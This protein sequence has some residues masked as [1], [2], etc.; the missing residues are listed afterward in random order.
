MCY[1]NPENG[2]VAIHLGYE[3]LYFTNKEVKSIIDNLK[4]CLKEGN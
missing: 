4:S 3:E 1:R 2:L